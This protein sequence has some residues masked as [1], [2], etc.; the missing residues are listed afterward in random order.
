MNR[1]RDVG[2]ARNKCTILVWEYQEKKAVE[3]PMHRWVNSIEVVMDLK[4]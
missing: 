2:E 3:T 1:I 4:I